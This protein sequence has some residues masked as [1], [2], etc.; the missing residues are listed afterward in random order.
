[1]EAG[2]R[3]GLA[4]LYVQ[5][6][7]WERA[8]AMLQSWFKVV[9]DPAPEAYFLIAQVCYELKQYERGL[10]NLA[11]AMKA[12]QQRGDAPREQWYVLLRALHHELGDTANT[13]RSLET[14]ARLWPKKEYFL[15]LS[16]IYGEMQRAPQQLAA[17]EAAYFAGWLEGESELVNLGYLYLDAGVPW[18]A[19]QLLEQ[20]LARQRI[21]ASPK[22]LELIGIAWRQARENARATDFLEQAAAAADDAEMWARLASFE[23]DEEHHQQAADAARKALALGGGRRPD[24]ARV[25]LGMALYGLRQ[26]EE[27]RSAFSA[28]A[29]DTRS[30]KI[31]TQWLR[32]LDNA[33]ERERL[34]ARDV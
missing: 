24:N 27:A 30:Q 31:A 32:F 33:I 26:Y 13:A 14:L 16:A 2:T 34:L 4:Q 22:N 19:A 29:T 7:D 21:E 6:A 17:M 20:S 8:S 28:A 9:E 1:M 5:T 10:H 25:V 15:Q 23:L 11:A 18:K 12:A 3:Y